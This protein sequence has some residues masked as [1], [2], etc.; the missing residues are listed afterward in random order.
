MG[1]PKAPADLTGSPLPRL[2]KLC[3]RRP[4]DVAQHRNRRR[5]IHTRHAA[6]R[7]RQLGC[8]RRACGARRR[9]RFPASPRAEAGRFVI[10]AATIARY[11]VDLRM[12]GEPSLNGRHFAIGQERPDT[13][14]LKIANDRPI[15]MV[16]A[17]GPELLE[18]ASSA[19]PAAA[20]EYKQNDD[21]D[22]K[23]RRV[24]S[25]LLRG[26]FLAASQ[27]ALLT[28]TRAVPLSMLHAC[29]QRK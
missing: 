19:V 21:N 3:R 12:G 8:G 23:C 17:E 22:Q 20:T 15:A 5:T 13:A 26:Y 28:L 9:R 6:V 27:A 25:C 4:L 18:P 16:S 7:M 29:R 2:F 1:T 11:D 14:A 10:A 24:H